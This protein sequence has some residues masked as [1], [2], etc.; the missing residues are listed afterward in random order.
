MRKIR[1]EL[2]SLVVGIALIMGVLSGCNTGTASDENEESMEETR[3]F[4]EIE[5]IG[6][7]QKVQFFMWGGN[8]RIN[9]YIDEFV[10]PNV[11][12]LYDIELVRVPM[13]APD[14]VAKVLNEK[15]SNIEEGTIDVLWI[16]AENFKILKDIGGLYG[17]FTQVLP[18]QSQYYDQEL[19]S[20]YYDSGIEIEGKEAIYGS[21]QLV[22][23]Y[24]SKRVE[25]PPK[26]YQ[27]IMAYAK[28]NEGKVT[29][30]N[31]LEDF[32]GSAFVRNA[33]FELTDFDR[34]KEY[35]FEEFEEL[36]EPVIEYFKELH[37]YLWKEGKAFPATV[38]LQDTMFINGEVDFTVAFEVYQPAGKI[39]AGEY[40]DTVRSYVLDTGTIGNSHY[41]AIPYNS[42]HKEG[43]ML[44]IN[45]LQSPEAQIEKMNPDVWG[46]LTPM[47]VHT[48]S[49]SEKKEIEALES[50]DA[51]V[52]VE[53]LYQKRVDDMNAEYIEW[54]EEIWE[55][56]II[57]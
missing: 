36:S 10:T 11:K 22:Y 39:E 12:E 55:K 44:V 15:K 16:N 24:D 25:N 46:D 54:I 34:G 50:N 56:E 8:E 13:E 5:T 18:N 52:P 17:P 45:Y 47:D 37:P 19:E 30:P 38:A 41:L 40:P 2:F 43:A 31:P 57:H 20:L 3:A 42:P 23:S 7:G 51:I 21:A 35:S 14:F 6:K 26:S 28:E 48:L 53:E 9:Q 27:E 32:V 4:E 49:E 33:Y 1:R 29:Y